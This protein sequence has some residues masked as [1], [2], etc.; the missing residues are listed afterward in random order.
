MDKLYIGDIPKEYHYA[1]FSSNYIDLFNTSNLYNGTYN[2]YRLY[3]YDNFFVYELS[4]RAFSN[5]NVT[6]ATNIEVT[7][8]IRYRRDFPDILQSVFIYVLLFVFLINLVTSCIKRG[9]LLS[10]L[11]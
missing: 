8:N 1:L 10:G 7:D 5:Y 6:V 3:L 11:L 2:F 4:S 9:G